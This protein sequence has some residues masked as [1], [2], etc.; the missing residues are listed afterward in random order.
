PRT[1]PPGHPI[2]PRN[3]PNMIGAFIDPAVNA[4]DGRSI[5]QEEYDSLG[6][7]YSK[8][9]IDELLPTLY[10]DYKISRDSDRHGIAG[11]SSGAIA[12]FTVAWERSDQFHKVLTGIGTFVDLK[13]GPGD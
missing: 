5:R 11:W 6:D 2:T 8:V 10:K 1:N 3:I 12:A 7:K 13:G 9:I 4:A